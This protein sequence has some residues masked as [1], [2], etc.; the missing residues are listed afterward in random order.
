MPINLQRKPDRDSGRDRRAPKEELLR[1]L[2]G[3]GRIL[4]VPF[5]AFLFANWIL[6]RAEGAP[7]PHRPRRSSSFGVPPLR[8]NRTCDT[9]YR[10]P[11]KAYLV[12]KTT[13]SSKRHN[14]SNITPGLIQRM[15]WKAE[16]E[17]IA[18]VASYCRRRDDTTARQTAR[19]THSPLPDDVSP[20][21]TCDYPKSR[22]HFARAWSTLRSI[23]GHCKLKLIKSQGSCRQHRTTPSTRTCCNAALNGGSWGGASRPLFLIIP[24]NSQ[25]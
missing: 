12:A 14:P 15:H 10:L 9:R 17:D 23:C 25:N 18:N 3:G 19:R 21:Q 2:V 13:V 8:K 11:R 16:R 20:S 24:L 22:K 7:A 5:R 6:Q 1:G 4:R